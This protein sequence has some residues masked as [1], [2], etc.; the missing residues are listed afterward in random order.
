VLTADDG[1]RLRGQRAARLDGRPAGTNEA[2]RTAVGPLGDS[3][4]AVL[5]HNPPTLDGGIL[6]PQGALALATS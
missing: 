2:Q 5:G 1:A 3:R 6:H 4:D